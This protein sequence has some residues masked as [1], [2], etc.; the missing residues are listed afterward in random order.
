VLAPGGLVGSIFYSSFFRGDISSEPAEVESSFAGMYNIF[1]TL[2][3]GAKKKKKTPSSMAQQVCVIVE[4]G[5]MEDAGFSLGA[6]KG[7]RKEAIL[8]ICYMLYAICYGYPL[9]MYFIRR[10]RGVDFLLPLE[11]S[12]D[13]HIE[14]SQIK[15]I[16]GHLKYQAALFWRASLLLYAGNW[17]KFLLEIS[18]HASNLVKGLRCQ[19]SFVLYCIPM[20]SGYTDIVSK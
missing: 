7:G 8:L 5:L 14:S 3:K 6:R 11:P 2:E 12:G 19:A 18:S 10:A 16:K 13:W 17:V 20:R 9:C 4:I 15:S 1:A